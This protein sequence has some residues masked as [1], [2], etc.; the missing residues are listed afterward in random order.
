MKIKTKQL[1]KKFKDKDALNSLSFALNEPKI[2]GLLGRNG[3][4]KTTFMDI[5]AGN[6]LP[7]S[8]DVF[9][10]EKRPFDNEQLMK[11]ICLI[12]EANNFDKELKIKNVFKIYSYFYPNWDM[13]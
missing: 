10:D 9:V 13:P 12:K 5:L 1:S 11:S 7:T 4:G 6:I 3:A 8:G 2:Y